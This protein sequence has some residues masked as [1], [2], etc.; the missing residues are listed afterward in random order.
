[1]QESQSNVVKFEE[2]VVTVI[3]F[4]HYVYYSTTNLTAAGWGETL[5]EE[6][7]LRSGLKHQADS[8]LP[9][10]VLAKTYSKISSGIS[11]SDSASGNDPT[12]LDAR[13]RL[14][15]LAD[16]YDVPG[17]RAQVLQKILAYH[18]SDVVGIFPLIDKFNEYCP[19][20]EDWK[21]TFDELLC[22]NRVRKQVLALL[23]EEDDRMWDWMQERKLGKRLLLEYLVAPPVTTGGAGKKRK[24]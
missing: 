23:T 20:S 7:L 18:Y 14:Y 6:A 9:P 24:K 13:V 22:D 3:R 15:A 16:T 17:L 10:E 2:D 11:A 4:L 19:A 12:I 5:D 21:M 1:V 8:S